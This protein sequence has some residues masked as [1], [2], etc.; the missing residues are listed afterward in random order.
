MRSVILIVQVAT[1]VALG[2]LF[3]TEGKW[4]LGAAQLLLAIIQGVIY[5]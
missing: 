4:R 1:F 5:S 2:I 3:L